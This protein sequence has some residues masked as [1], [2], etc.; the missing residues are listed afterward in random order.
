LLL[1]MAEPRA[2][3]G[4]PLLLP[5]CVLGAVEVDSLKRGFPERSTGS[6]S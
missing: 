3:Y 1:S 6:A 5:L 2:I 4:M